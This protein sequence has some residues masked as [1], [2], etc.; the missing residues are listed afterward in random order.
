M[1]AFLRAQPLIDLHLHSN[2]SDGTETP[3]V[4]V[5]QAHQ[6]GVRTMALTDHDMTDGWAE[7]AAACTAQ[8]MTFI[9]GMELTTR[10]TIGGMHLLCYLFDPADPTLVAELEEQQDAREQRAREIVR[11]LAE[12][13]DITWEDVRRHATDD[14]GFGRPAIGAAMLE[15]GHVSTLNEVFT[16]IVRKGTKYYVP[17]PGLNIFDAIRL[18]RQAGGVPVIAHPTG[19]SGGVMPKEALFKLLDAGIGGF[20]LDHR[21]NKNNP[22]G[23]AKLWEYARAYDL[24]VT[25][26]SDYHGSRKENRPGENTTSAEMLGRIIEQGTGSSPVYPA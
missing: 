15:K 5:E 23:L 10:G 13:Y 25:G 1:E 26:S 8:G 21:E 22:E 14:K 7:A 12:D 20:E 6:H 24:I 4:V 18:I 17:S 16:D 2:H 19:R 3:S 9:P 11:L